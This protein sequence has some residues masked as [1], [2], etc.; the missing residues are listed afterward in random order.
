MVCMNGVVGSIVDNERGG[1]IMH[2]MEP[3]VYLE[4]TELWEFLEMMES[5]VYLETTELWEYLETMESQ[6]LFGDDGALGIFKDDGT[7]GVFGDDGA[8]RVFGDDGALG[9]LGDDGV[10]GPFGDD[11]ALGVLLLL[12]FTDSFGLPLKE[13]L[14][15]KGPRCRIVLHLASK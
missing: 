9:V 10:A 12:C 6:V 15:S 8:W 13:T 3:Q 1:L 7:L 11:V 14:F 4:T 5:Q 2:T